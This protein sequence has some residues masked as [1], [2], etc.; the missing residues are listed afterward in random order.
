VTCTE[1]KKRAADGGPFLDFRVISPGL[2]A[3]PT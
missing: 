1:K 2:G 3:Y